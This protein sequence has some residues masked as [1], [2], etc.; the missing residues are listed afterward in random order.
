MPA[1]S[2]VLAIPRL[3]FWLIAVIGLVSV[4][5]VLLD[6]RAGPVARLLGLSVVVV[7]FAL[8]L[9]V[10]FRPRT[11]TADSAGI[12]GDPFYRLDIQWEDLT[13]PVYRGDRDELYAQ[14][15]MLTSRRNGASV[16]RINAGRFRTENG[17]ELIVVMDS[18]PDVDVFMFQT[19]QSWHL[20]SLEPPGELA[21]VFTAYAPH[22][23]REG[24]PEIAGGDSPQN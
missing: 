14:G 6:R 3:W 16:G 9:F 22:G 13:S 1:F 17:T 23:L 18:A 4:V 12:R 7:V 21:A 20:I 5:V 15:L 10:A 8:V 19:D 2:T 11:F 24:I